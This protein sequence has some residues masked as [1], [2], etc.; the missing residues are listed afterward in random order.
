MVARRVHASSHGRIDLGGSEWPHPRH[1]RRGREIA[2]NL[3]RSLSLQPT[4]QHVGNLAIPT[5]RAARPC[6]GGRGWRVLCDRR[7][8][9]RWRRYA[10]Q[11]FQSRRGLQ[12]RV[13]PL[14]YRKIF[15]LRMVQNKCRGSELRVKLGALA[16]GNPNALCA[17]QVKEL[18]LVGEVGT[19]RV[20]KRIP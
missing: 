7:L 4:D 11:P 6:L 20:T 16:K 12:G 17:Q 1:W 9:R 2:H 14:L 19:R 3:R 5:Y 13:R 10:H 8:N 15:G 18:P